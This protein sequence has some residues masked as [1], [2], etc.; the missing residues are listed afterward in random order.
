VSVAVDRSNNTESLLIAVLLVAAGLGM[1]AAQTGRLAWLCA[2]MAAVGVGFN[3]KMGIAVLLAPVI[4]SAFSL[5]WRTAPAAW[6]LHRQAVA[7]LVLVV[8]SLSWVAVFD[9]TP[10]ADRPYAGST[11]HNSML[12]LALGAQWGRALPASDRAGRRRGRFPDIAS[13]RAGRHVSDRAIAP[14]PPAA[15]RPG[16]VA[17]AAGARRTGIRLAA[18]GVRGSAV[19]ASHRC[20][21]LDRLAHRLLARAQLRGRDRAYLLH[22]RACAAAGGLRRSGCKLRHRSCST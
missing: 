15:G 5:A 22:G 2:A 16:G 13:A 14:V 7:G 18:P 1:K 12:E 8:V 11:R 20:R 17:A 10:A 19:D 3:V 4:A 21:H 9:L 6:H